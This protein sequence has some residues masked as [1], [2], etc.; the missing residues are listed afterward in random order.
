MS[1][2]CVDR[3]TNFLQHVILQIR[4]LNEIYQTGFIHLGIYLRFDEVVCDDYCCSRVDLSNFLDDVLTDEEWMPRTRHWR[5]KTYD[6]SIQSDYR[7]CR[8]SSHPAKNT[9][10]PSSKS[11]Q[12]VQPCTFESAAKW[13]TPPP[14]MNNYIDG[15]IKV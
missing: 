14:T 5:K 12:G 4:H 3:F 8:I 1:L 9:E 2:S 13:K 11:N 7:R 10:P 6:R 15:L